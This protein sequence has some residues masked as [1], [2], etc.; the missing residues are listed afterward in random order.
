VDYE[1]VLMIF[2]AM[3]GVQGE[4]PLLILVS[5]VDVRNPDKIPAHYLRHTQILSLKGLSQRRMTD[6]RRYR[7][8]E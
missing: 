4:K 8:G 3:E 7:D 5:A 1:G 6:R 2:D